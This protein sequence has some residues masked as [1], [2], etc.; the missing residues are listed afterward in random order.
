V[1]KL[2]NQVAGSP[3]IRRRIAEEPLAMARAEGYAVFEEDVRLL[4]GA[5]DPSGQDVREILRINLSRFGQGKWY[6]TE[7]GLAS[8]P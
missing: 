5:D 2:I 8:A 7:R 6:Q 4:L 3:A 1:Q